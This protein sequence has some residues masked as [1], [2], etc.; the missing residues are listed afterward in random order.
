M[1]VVKQNTQEKADLTIGD[2]SKQYENKK[3]LCGR[4]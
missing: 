4:K 3:D 2:K 1:V